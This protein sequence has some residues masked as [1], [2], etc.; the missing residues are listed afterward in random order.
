MLPKT[1]S[2]PECERASRARG[3]CQMHYGRAVRAGAISQRPNP[4]PETCTAS[5]CAKAHFSSGFCGTHYRAA[6]PPCAFDGCTKPTHAQGYCGQHYRRIQ[7]YGDVNEASIIVGDDNAR[8]WS[9]VSKGETCWE[10]TG[11]KD[12]G[13]Y[14]SF[15]MGGKTL[16]AHRVSFEMANGTI[17]DGLDIDHRCHNRACV[18][19]NHLR[20]TSRKQNV[21]NHSGISRNNKSGV[22]GVHWSGPHKKWRAQVGH[23]GRSV[24]VGLFPSTEEAEAAVI[25][26]RNEL[27][28][29][30]DLDRVKV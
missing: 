1:C 7:R 21:E 22:R 26:K 19:P 25:A 20:P 9:K 16:G 14:G 8:F 13:G 18:N 30:N 24:F 4:A 5:G 12:P 28:T 23:N 11:T 15:P 29:H 27:H 10:W 3:M 2:I 17:P 6:K